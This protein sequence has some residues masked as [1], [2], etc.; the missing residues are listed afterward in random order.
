MQGLYQVSGR[1]ICKGHAKSQAGTAGTGVGFPEDKREFR[2]R[3]ESGRFSSPKIFFAKMF[4]G[5][6]H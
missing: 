6:R 4:F 3:P 5:L 1:R 2:I